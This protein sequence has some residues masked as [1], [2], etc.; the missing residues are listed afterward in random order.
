MSHQNQ[1]IHVNSPLNLAITNK[2]PRFGSWFFDAQNDSISDTMFTAGLDPVDF[3]KMSRK[4]QTRVR[5]PNQ[6]RRRRRK[7]K[8]IVAQ[9]SNYGSKKKEILEINKVPRAEF[10]LPGNQ[11]YLDTYY[12]TL[13]ISICRE[14]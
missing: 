6:H 10:L 11:I 1:T 13:P 4:G 3:I 12:F 14:L 8:R 2:V 9:E 5:P 7:R